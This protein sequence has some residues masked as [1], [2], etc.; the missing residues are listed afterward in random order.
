MRIIWPRRCAPIARSRDAVRGR[1][2]VDCAA[3]AAA[4][5]RRVAVHRGVRARPLQQRARTSARFRRPISAAPASATSARSAVRATARCWPSSP[6]AFRCELD[7]RGDAGRHQPARGTKVDAVDDEGHDRRPL[8]A[9]SRRRPTCCARTASSSTAACPSASRTRSRSSSSA[10]S[11]TS[12]WS[13]PAIRSACSATIWCSRSRRA[14]AP[15]AARQCR[16][17]A[18]VGGL[19]RRQVRPRARRAGRQ[20]DGRVRRGMAQRHVRH[21]REEAR[22]GAPRSTQWNKEPW[23]QGAIATASPGW[24]GARRILMEP[25]RNRVFFAGEAVHETAW[26][27]VGGAWESGDARGRRGGAPRPGPARACR[28]RRPSRTPVAAAAAPAPRRSR[29]QQA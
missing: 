28:R 8:H 26:G 21:Q 19:G 1:A 11:I 24:Q 27:T 16:R 2:D 22:C 6:K 13:S 5:S 3:R 20:G 15:R 18:A 25:I 9:S 14:R 17:H 12:R 7:T 29:P 10:A 23:A 4:R